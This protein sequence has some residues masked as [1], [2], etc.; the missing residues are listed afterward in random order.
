MEIIQLR[1]ATIIIKSKD[2]NILVDPMLSKK[3]SQI[4]FKWITKNIRKNP[5]VGL[6]N[7][8]EE[9]LSKV[10]HTLITHCQKGHFD[11]LDKLA[12]KFLTNK[13]TQV[14]C[15]ARDYLY[16]RKKKLNVSLLKKNKQNEFLNGTVELTECIHGKGWINYFM[17]HGVGYFIKLNN[18][19]SIYL[20]GDTVL[21]D[22]VKQFI[23]NNQPDIV[24][25]PAGKAKLDLGQPILMGIE[26]ILELAEIMNGKLIANHLEALDH[27][28]VSRKDLR[29]AIYEE[30][31]SQKIL[32]PEDG[33]TI[34]IN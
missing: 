20:T 27:C 33:E 30:G 3:G 18:E 8:A 31:L 22:Y 28:S 16:L 13:N 9:E 24:V 1:N 5:I 12:I 19:P 21:T 34:L 6:P 26:E 2:L 29:N 23:E 14:F 25:A 11:H 4:P 32:V 15:S 10:T 17:E 7:N